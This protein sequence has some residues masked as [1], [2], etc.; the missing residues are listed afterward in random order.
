MAALGL[1]GFVNSFARV[2]DA[3]RS[4]FGWFAFTVPIGIDVGIAVFSALDIVLARLDMR[5]RWLRLVPWSLTGATVYLNIAGEHSAFGIVA[6]AMLPT[7]WIGAVE[8]AAHVVRTRAGLA[9]GTRLDSIRLSRWLLSPASTVRLW[10]RMVLWETRSY[11]SALMRERD[12]VLSL[13]DLKDTYGAVAWRWRA[14]RRTKALY[15]LGELVP[16]ADLPAAPGVLTAADDSADRPADRPADEPASSHTDERTA[17][18]TAT[19]GGLGR[20]SQPGSARRRRRSGTK[21]RTVP[22]VDDLMPI[23]RGIAAEADER[24]VPLTRD[25]LATA[26]REAG[27]PAGNERV[28]ALLIRLKTMTASPDDTSSEGGQS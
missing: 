18:R 12:R 13:T 27:R 25:S 23:G 10:R 16:V 28:G 26:L 9:A 2:A 17:H 3:A 4:S 19:I 14:P 8:V 11:P 6:H 1:L 24:G 21:R 15:K 22:D 20:S 5:I 7:L